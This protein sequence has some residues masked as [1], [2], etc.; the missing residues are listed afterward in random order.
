MAKIGWG[1]I[2]AGVAAAAA[3]G[4]AYVYLK[5]RAARSP[6]H[7]TLHGEGAFEIRRYPAL[8][9]AETV[10]HG[11]R[12][13][14]LGNGFGLLAD[15]MFG[16]KREGDEIPM[17]V[18]VL[19]VPEPGGSWRVRFLM[20]EGYTKDT[21]PE[22]GPGIEIAELAARDVAAV[23]FGSK[24]TDRL[25]A[26]QEADLRAWIARVGQVSAGMAEQ[27]YYNSPLRPGP[28]RQNE[29]LIPLQ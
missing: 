23:K 14:A 27:A 28:I 26:A 11:S 9:V 8:L 21:L 4:A 2:L 19:A 13:R 20:P 5:D 24:P 16:E 7:E 10:Q 6:V 1:R 25:L 17:T 15:Y 12:D 22:P 3:A 18:P 29:V